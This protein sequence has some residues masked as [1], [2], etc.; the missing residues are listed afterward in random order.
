MVVPLL[1]VVGVIGTLWFAYARIQIPNAP[2]GPQTTFV[3]DRHGKLV[4]TFHAEVN[5]TEISFDQMPQS[6]KDAVI[7]VEDKGYYHHGGVSV[8]GIVRAAWQDLVHRS[9]VQGGSTITQQ[10]V[11]NVYTGS[12]RTFGRK[13]KEALLAVKLEHEYSKNQILEK[14]LNTVYFGHGAYGVQAAAKTYWGED[15]KNL[16]LLQDATLAGAINAPSAKPALRMFQ[17]VRVP[18]G[19]ATSGKRMPATSLPSASTLGTSTG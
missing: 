3:Y 4:T 15:A 1:V 2:P 10:Y 19:T 9:A 12:E 16:T 8:V 5:R 14:Y 7:A 6:I 11:K 13:I 18:S 17:P